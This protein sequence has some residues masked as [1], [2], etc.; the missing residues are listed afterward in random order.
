MY[1]KPDVVIGD[2]VTGGERAD[3]TKCRENRRG[4]RGQKKLNSNMQ[5]RWSPFVVHSQDK[6]QPATMEAEITATLCYV[7]WIIA[8]LLVCS[9]CHLLRAFLVTSHRSL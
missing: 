7:I 1:N 6:V 3:G 5:E 4:R 8:G 2:D 9:K